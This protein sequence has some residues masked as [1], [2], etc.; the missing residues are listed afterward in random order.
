MWGNEVEIN[1]TQ[2][3]GGESQWLTWNHE[4]HILISVSHWRQFFF[5]SFQETQNK[6]VQRVLR[7]F[8][9]TFFQ[10]IIF[11]PFALKCLPLHQKS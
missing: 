8:I 9:L 1:T 4:S 2:C 3:P 10:S 5:P 6:S 7:Q 11:L